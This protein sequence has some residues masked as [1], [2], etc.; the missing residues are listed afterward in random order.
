MAF[1]MLGSGWLYEKFDGIAFFSMAG[2]A[3]LGI[4]VLPIVKLLS[5]GR[6]RL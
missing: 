1:A 5:A 4:L 6:T 3:F 2:M